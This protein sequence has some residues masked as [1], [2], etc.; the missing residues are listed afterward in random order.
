[1]FQRCLCILSDWLHT[2][3]LYLKLQH[4][5]LIKFKVCVSKC[6]VYFMVIC[7]SS[8]TGYK[9]KPLVGILCGGIEGLSVK[10]GNV[11]KCTLYQKRVGQQFSSPPLP[12][13]PLPLV[14]NELLILWYNV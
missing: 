12:P 6:Q 1:M 5:I 7:L 11:R 9:M 14:N 3:V 13:P 4:F 10:G 8:V 2:V